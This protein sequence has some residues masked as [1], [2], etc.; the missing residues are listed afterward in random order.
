[1]K[2]QSS[3]LAYKYLSIR[4][5]L[6]RFHFRDFVWPAIE[7][8]AKEKSCARLKVKNSVH[9]AINWPLSKGKEIVVFHAVNLRRSECVNKYLSTHWNSEI[10]WFVDSVGNWQWLADDEVWKTI[11]AFGFFAILIRDSQQTTYQLLIYTTCALNWV[12][13]RLHECVNS[14]S[15]ATEVDNFNNTWCF[16]IDF[17]ISIPCVYK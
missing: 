12:I 14:P 13:T 7:V 3:D 9:D 15:F 4:L 2:K 8:N 17:W 10:N 1:M 16:I 5:V 11:G 6:L